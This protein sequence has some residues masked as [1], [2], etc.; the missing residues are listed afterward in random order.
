MKDKEKA[1][2]E[3][4]PLTLET[5]VEDG[6][7]THERS[8]KLHLE[9]I[10]SM[11]LYDKGQLNRKD[12]YSIWRTIFEKEATVGI[13]GVQSITLAWFNRNRGII[14]NAGREHLAE[15]LRSCS[16]PVKALPNY[17]DACDVYIQ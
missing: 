5:L 11:M 1:A 15:K 12:I 16:D 4:T 8:V 6:F 3:G 14:T 10:S 17:D 13:P 2:L 9:V 7:T